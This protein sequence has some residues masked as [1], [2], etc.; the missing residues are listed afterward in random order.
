MYECVCVKDIDVIHGFATMLI[1]VGVNT[2]AK[3][4]ILYM[5]MYVC[6]FVCMHI[7][8]VLMCMNTSALHAIT[9]IQDC[10][11]ISTSVDTIEKC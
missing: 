4:T 10:S 11:T 1:D 9:Y 2:C 8:W 3:T 7:T 5:L 6:V